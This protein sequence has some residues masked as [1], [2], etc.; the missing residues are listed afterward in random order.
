MSLVQAFAVAT[1]A[2]RLVETELGSS[3][4]EVK[5]DAFCTEKG[6]GSNSRLAHSVISNG[7]PRTFFSNDPSAMVL[8]PNVRSTMGQK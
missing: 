4:P 2:T 5:D 6:T 3:L 8:L 1:I 7:F